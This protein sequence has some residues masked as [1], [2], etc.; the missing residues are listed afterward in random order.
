MK[1]LSVRFAALLLIAAGMVA[2]T[3]FASDDQHNG[4]PEESTEKVVLQ[5]YK[6]P[7]CGCCSVWIDHLQ[8]RGFAAHIRHP[9]NLN[10]VKRNFRVPA[11]YQSCHT[12]VTE[13][14]YVFEGHIPA[15]IIKQFLREKPKDAIGLTVPAMPVGS[16]GMESGD[17]FMPYQ[18][19]LLNESGA[20]RVYAEVR[21]R[22]EQY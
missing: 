16:P 9:R 8:E 14:G 21:T 19:L 10:Q 7:T 11:Q 3:S 4:V 18:V 12:A 20:T 17:K 22:D 1:S 15:K 5:V 13:D 6:S 2:T